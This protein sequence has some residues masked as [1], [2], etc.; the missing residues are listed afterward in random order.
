MIAQRAISENCAMDFDKAVDY[1]MSFMMSEL[2]SQPVSV[3]RNVLATVEG[4]VLANNHYGKWF[5][6]NV[7]M[8][9]TLAPQF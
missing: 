9:E 4:L 6:E 5:S 1:Q 3:T 7:G 2:E 8:G